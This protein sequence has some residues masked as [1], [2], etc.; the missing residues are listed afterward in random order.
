M[1]KITEKKI[2]LGTLAILSLGCARVFAMDI[3]NIRV[4]AD[5]FN[6]SSFQNIKAQASAQNSQK[7]APHL[8]SWNIAPQSLIFSRHLKKLISSEDFKE[9]LAHLNIV[10][11]GEVHTVLVDHQVQAA[12]LHQMAQN[13]PRLVL[14]I[15]MADV[16]HQQYLDYY[17]SGKIPESQFADFWNHTFGDFKA[18]RPI[19][20]EAKRDHIRIIAL[21]V[22]QAIEHKA[23]QQGLSSLTPQERALLPRKIGEIKNPR[24]YAML[25]NSFSDLPP[26]EMKRYLFSMQIWNETMASNVVR[27]RRLGNSVMVIAGLGHI[28]YGGGIPEGVK[29][30]LKG[31]SSAVIL[32]FPPDGDLQS[33]KTLLQKLLAPK[34]DE[35]HW[36]DFFWLLPSAA[37]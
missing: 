13:H 24:Y 12:I 22:P 25:K 23:A 35:A 11:V 33:E 4:A 6:F 30:R 20:E 34:S 18:Y 19:I 17:I 32:P 2:F 8:L 14:G 15:E 1:N 9:T 31:E 27:Q 16:L 5:G 10:Y 3:E 37:Q 21:N 29:R 26:E 7:P 28:L 36:A